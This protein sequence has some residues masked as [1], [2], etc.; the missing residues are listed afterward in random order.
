MTRSARGST[1][2]VDR[3]AGRYAL[4]IYWLA[5]GNGSRVTTGELREYL[6][7]TPASVTEMV[8][9]LDESGLVDHEKYAGVRLT[10]AGRGV[11]TRL[12]WRFCV[13]SNFFTTVLETELD[14][15]DSYAIGYT[16]PDNGVERLHELIDHPCIDRCPETSQDYEGCLI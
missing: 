2:T 11:A 4:A 10:E 14:D 1:P 5:E 3:T 12:A 8:G 9:K 16:L 13:V 15:A 7:V 6:E